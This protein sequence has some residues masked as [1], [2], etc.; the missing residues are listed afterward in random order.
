MQ[1]QSLR[2]NLI[3]SAVVIISVVCWFAY[4]RTHQ[5][6]PETVN[7]TYRNSCCE[8]IVLKNGQFITSEIEIPFEL[9]NMK[10]GLDTKMNR[11]VI[12]QNGQIVLGRR[13]ESGGFLFRPD[14]RAF[15]LCAETCSREFE[16]KRDKSLSM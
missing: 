12:V 5:P 15:T 14:G 2:L 13:E 10:Y 9:R 7:G 8:P 3:V 11:Y 6:R 4:V 1:I 16:F